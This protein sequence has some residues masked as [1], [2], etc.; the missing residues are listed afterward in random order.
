M[1]KL[2]LQAHL[3]SRSAYLSVD[4]ALAC[5]T[6]PDRDQAARFL[7]VWGVATFIGTM[8][9]P[10]LAGPLLLFFGNMEDPELQGVHYAQGGYIAILTVGCVCM[11]ASAVLI[12]PIDAR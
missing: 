11:I 12:R 2:D 1:A 3:R 10:L 9:G 6:L 4:Y 5:H 8:V 7:G